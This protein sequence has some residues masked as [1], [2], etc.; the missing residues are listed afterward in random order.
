MARASRR[1]AAASW[2]PEMSNRPIAR[3]PAPNQTK[4]PTRNAAAPVPSAHPVPPATEPQA[5]ARGLPSR[6]HPPPLIPT[7]SGRAQGPAPGA[8]SCA[9]AQRRWRNLSASVGLSCRSGYEARRRL[10]PRAVRLGAPG[11]RGN[12]FGGV[13]AGEPGP[14]LD[15]DPHSVAV[16]HRKGQKPPRPSRYNAPLHLHPRYAGHGA[17]RRSGIDRLH[18]HGERRRG[19]AVRARSIRGGRGY[20]VTSS[21]G[22]PCRW[23]L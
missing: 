4:S 20:R 13:G 14:R 21:L 19:R 23:A 15:P 22:A 3:K 12:L 18:P 16:R 7:T 6:H 10:S 5:Q 8:E 17:A 1:A 11:D 9:G 2:P